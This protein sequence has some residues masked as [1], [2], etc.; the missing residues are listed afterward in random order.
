MMKIY[1]DNGSCPDELKT[2][3]KEGAVKLVMF[4]YENK[5]RHIKNSGQPSAATW[6]DM[7]NYTWAD[8]PGTY[9]DYKASDKH[10]EIVNIVGLKN[11]RVDILHLDSA[12]KTGVDAFITNDKDDILS[13]RDKLEKALGFRFFHTSEIEELTKFVN[14]ANK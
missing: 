1:C 2:L 10:K 14:S 11:K 9:N 3:Q 13:Y 5:N 4:K 6:N 7:K 12:Y 8:V